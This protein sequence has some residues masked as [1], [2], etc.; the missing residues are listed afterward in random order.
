MMNSDE[1]LDESVLVS[2][3]EIFQ[4]ETQAAVVADEVQEE[5]KQEQQHKM[6]ETNELPKPVENPS[7]TSSP[8]RT[9]EQ[10]KPVA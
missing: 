5:K 10:Q 8:P 2:K 4:G 7:S 3:D 1:I 6:N 9:T